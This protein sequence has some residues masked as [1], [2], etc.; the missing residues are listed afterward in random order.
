MFRKEIKLETKICNFLEYGVKGA[1]EVW[2]GV[3]KNFFS[4]VFILP[5]LVILCIVFA[6]FALI[7]WITGDDK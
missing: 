3:A 4:Y 6:P 1:C 5:T 7:N 2:D